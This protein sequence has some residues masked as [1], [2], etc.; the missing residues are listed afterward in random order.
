MVGLGLDMLDVEDYVRHNDLG[1]AVL[2]RAARGRP[3]LA[4]GL[5]LAS[6][7]VVYGEGAYRCA[8]H[9]SVAPA[10]RDLED[11]AAGGSRRDARRV[12]AS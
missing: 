11:L 7:M 5:V 1:T 9:G 3:V 10:P 8:E 2:L 4:V 12:T 6:S